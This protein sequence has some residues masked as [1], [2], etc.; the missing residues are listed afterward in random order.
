MF[1]TP[2]LCEL[3]P[4]LLGFFHVLFYF[5]RAQ[6]ATC[7][8]LLE[9]SP[10]V[11]WG[12]V[13]KVA[14]HS[15]IPYICSL[16]VFFPESIHVLVHIKEKE[17]YESCLLH[18]KPYLNIVMYINLILQSSPIPSRCYFLS[19]I[20]VEKTTIDFSSPKSQ[21]NQTRTDLDLGRNL[22]SM[23]MNTFPHGSKCQ[24][25][26]LICLN[27][28]VFFRFETKATFNQHFL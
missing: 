9:F 14:I 28:T 3:P 19:H 2:L 4:L 25:E 8:P 22:E 17:T 13:N 24:D 1:P 5:I 15:S 26:P 6:K 27:I 21:T 16:F 18:A 12:T 20:S 7:F 23:L 10:L 11:M